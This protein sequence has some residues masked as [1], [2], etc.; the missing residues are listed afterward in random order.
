MII[1][2]KKKPVTSVPEVKSL[3]FL[4][5]ASE[6][7]LSILFVELCGKNEKYRLPALKN[8]QSEGFRT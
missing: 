5:R 6:N 7:I 3:Y 4:A 1:S 8:E 2:I